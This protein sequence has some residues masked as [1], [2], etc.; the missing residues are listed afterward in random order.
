MADQMASPSADSW[1]EQRV[2]R[3]A[4]SKDSRMA[5]LREYH[6]ADWWDQQW[7]ARLA[8]CW[9][10]QWVAPTVCYWAATRVDQWA[11]HWVCQRADC[12]DEQWVGY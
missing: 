12:W 8:V 5:G 2:A 3:T 6:W 4:E 11:A 7:A 1:A 10:E 9:V